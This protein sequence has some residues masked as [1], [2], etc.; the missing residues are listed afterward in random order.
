MTLFLNASKFLKE[1]NDLSGFNLDK[2]E[3]FG[4]QSGVYYYKIDLLV[5]INPIRIKEKHNQ[6]YLVEKFL[7]YVDEVKE[8]EKSLIIKTKLTTKRKMSGIGFTVQEL[9]NKPIIITW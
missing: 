1:S 9:G 7:K 6:K 5:N 4:I 8:F 3:G 2:V